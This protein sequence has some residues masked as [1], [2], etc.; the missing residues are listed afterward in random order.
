MATSTRHFRCSIQIK[1]ASKRNS[2]YI[3]IEKLPIFV[4]GHPKT[5]LFISHCGNLGT[6]EA[7]YHGVPTLAMPVAFD[8]HRNAIRLVKQGFG[9]QLNWDELT[10]DSLK[11]TID[12]LLN[13]RKLG[14]KQLKI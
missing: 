12:V 4:L 14:L 1:Q 8:Q 2:K 5:L 13:D 6:Q 10:E 9:L 11:E 3:N 7:K